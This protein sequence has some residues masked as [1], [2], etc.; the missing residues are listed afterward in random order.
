MKNW[1]CFLCLLLSAIMLYL[2]SAYQELQQT[3]VNR[4]SDIG[5]D[6][7]KRHYEILMQN[8]YSFLVINTTVPSYNALSFQNNLLE[9]L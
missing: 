6:E 3:A 2:C 7:F 4:S 8:P 5:F 9:G 1:V